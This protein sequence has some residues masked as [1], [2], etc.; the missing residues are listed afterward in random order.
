MGKMRSPNYPAIG[1]SAAVNRAREICDKEKRTVVSLDVAA[2]AIGYKSLSGPARTALAA[3]KKYGLL[4]DEK[5]GVRISELA[6]RV[7]HSEDGS[8]EQGEAL[9]E[10]AMKPEIFRVLLATHAD[11]SDAALRSHLMTTKR[12]TEEGARRFI[13]S[14]MDIV[15]IAKLEDSNYTEANNKV[16]KEDMNTGVLGT[17]E[18]SKVHVGGFAR[19]AN[20][21]PIP[22]KNKNQAILSFASLPLDKDDL[23]RLK[24]WIDLFESNL[25][26]PPEDSTS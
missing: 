12:F 10:A 14:F 17:E 2:K 21:F 23:E 4:D 19:L 18:T 20:S 11:A 25:T 1:L 16:E 26:E 5:G 24:K 7:L 22:L 15:R 9:R 3:L 13:P 8:K 6:V